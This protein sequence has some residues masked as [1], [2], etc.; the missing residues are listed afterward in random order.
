ME[1]KIKESGVL[2]VPDADDK[3]AMADD[4][5]HALVCPNCGNTVFD[6][7]PIT[8]YEVY[9]GNFHVGCWGGFGY[10]KYRWIPHRCTSCGT[11]F[12]AWTSSE[13]EP[14]ANV[15][16]WFVVL[17]V[18][19]ILACLCVAIALTIDS[20][21]WILAILSGVLMSSCIV[22]IDDNT[23][24]KPDDVMES[25]KNSANFPSRNE[26]E[27]KTHAPNV[28]LQSLASCCA[29][30]PEEIRELTM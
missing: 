1:P 22:G 28:M 12:V 11:N 23:F 14:N 15:I 5:L 10:V 20:F 29:A 24:S 26:E 13:K 25:I 17:T 18:L 9:K 3:F 8:C 7:K 27:Q 2:V 19:T 30:T 21:C 4:G 6:G 16:G